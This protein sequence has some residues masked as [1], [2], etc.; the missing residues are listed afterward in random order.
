MIKL[1][2]AALAALSL[3]TPA[4]ALTWEEFWEP[5]DHDHIEHHHHYHRPRPRMCTKY[6]TKK[7]YVPG[8]YRG[9]VW[10]Y[11]HWTERSR[12]KRVPCYTL[13]RHAF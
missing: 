7:R 5:F 11:G 4:Q 13:R 9:N 6:V 2:L 12:Q 1:T 10:I 8:H 3:A